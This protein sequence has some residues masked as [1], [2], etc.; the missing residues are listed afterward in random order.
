MWVD[1]VMNMTPR[2]V[3]LMQRVNDAQG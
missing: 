3:A 1:A 2:Q